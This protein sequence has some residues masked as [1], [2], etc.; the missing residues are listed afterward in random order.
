VGVVPWAIYLTAS[1]EFG[2]QK[3]NLS[4]RKAITFGTN[5]KKSRWEEERRAIYLGVKRGN[6]K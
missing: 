6:E 2:F 1:N 3:E 5:K 4:R